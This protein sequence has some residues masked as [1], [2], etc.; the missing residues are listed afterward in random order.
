MHDPPINPRIKL[1]FEGAFLT[2]HYDEIASNFMYFYLTVETNGIFRNIS[3]LYSIGIANQTELDIAEEIER[4]MTIQLDHSDYESLHQGDHTVMKINLLTQM[5]T[6]FP[7]NFVYDH[8]PL[9][10]NLGII[11]AAVVLIGLYVLIVLELVHRTLAAVLGST[12]A[13]GET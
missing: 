11:L 10:K 1:H 5:T 3:E 6:S 12:T 2:E 9:D 13:I 8:A 4:E 7:M